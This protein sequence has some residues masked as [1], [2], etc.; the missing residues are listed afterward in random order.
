MRA[1]SATETLFRDGP[2]IVSHLIGCSDRQARVFLGQMRKVAQNDCSR[3]LSIL[4]QG[5]SLHP[6]QDA[7]AWLM[8]AANGNNRK[9]DEMPS[10]W[11][12]KAIHAA[13]RCDVEPPI[14]DA[15][16]LEE[17]YP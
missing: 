4:H 2:P 17:A 16:M 15:E 8:A 10:S 5:Q 11:A 1:P 9:R 6:L 14:I 3:V 13:F 12:T 7:K